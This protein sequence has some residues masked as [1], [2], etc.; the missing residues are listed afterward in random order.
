MI[1]EVRLTYHSLIR[2]FE[3]VH[4]HRE[5]TVGMRAILEF[6]DREGPRTVPQIARA[7]NVTRQHIQN[8]V[9]Q[10]LDQHW[11]EAI[12]NPDHK[13]SN[14]ISV[15]PKGKSEF[16]SMKK[17]EHIFYQSIDWGLDPDQAKATIR[18]LKKFKEALNREVSK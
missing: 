18:N 10:L 2:A 14:L 17:E 16:D 5:V 13:S 11:V 15:T 7:R 12:E 6:I 1:N 4:G 8:L 3:A 9:N